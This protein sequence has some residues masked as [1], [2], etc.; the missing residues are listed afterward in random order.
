GLGAGH[1]PMMHRRLDTGEQRFCCSRAEAISAGGSAM[2]RSVAPY[3]FHMSEL[4]ALLRWS[5]E[6]SIPSVVAAST[7]AIAVLAMGPALLGRPPTHRYLL[8]NLAL[9]WVPFV[10]ALGIEG[11][12]PARRRVLLAACGL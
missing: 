2:I 3:A 1:A 12:S 6:R 7:L 11:V 8:W 10:A 9:A 5:S 4:R